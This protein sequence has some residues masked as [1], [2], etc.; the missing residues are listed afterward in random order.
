MEPE[1]T[2]DRVFSAPQQKV[3][4]AYSKE[5]HLCNWWG[6]TPFDLV[7]CELD[8]Q[9]NG[10]FFYGLESTDFK[11]HGVFDY[12]E[13]DAPNMIRFLNYFADKNGFPVRHPKSDT[14][15]IKMMN[16]ITFK[17]KEEQTEMHISVTAYEANETEL[18]TFRAG[19]D[20]L[21][22]GFKGTLD[23]LGEYLETME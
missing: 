17:E 20:A 6:S 18:K 5:K 11:M 7:V 13:I 22:A 3:F 15:P 19:L 2:I 10:R 8:F 21:E 9:V 14:W 23:K 1:F 12:L 16:S 4:D